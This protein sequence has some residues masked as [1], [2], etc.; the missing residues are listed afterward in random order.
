[1]FLAL[2]FLPDKETTSFFVTEDPVSFVDK[3]IG[4]NSLK[5]VK[6]SIPLVT[7]SV[8]GVAIDVPD[9]LLQEVITGMDLALVGKFLAFRTD[10]DQICKWAGSVWK[11]KGSVSIS[12]MVDGFF[13]S[14]LLTRK[15]R[16]KYPIEVEIGLSQDVLMFNTVLTT[17]IPLKCKFGTRIQPIVYENANIYCLFCKQFG[18]LSDKMFEKS[19]TQSE[20]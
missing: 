1:M 2:S 5:S 19:I 12:V 13:C 14:I 20:K 10:V 18:H 15:I 11:L 3:L 4:Q 8:E 16:S 9:D 7:S 6:G 17:R